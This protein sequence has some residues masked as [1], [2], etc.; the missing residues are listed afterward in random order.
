MSND[1]IGLFNNTDT[2]ELTLAFVFE[3]KKYIAKVS[4]QT[5]Q[6]FSVKDS[7]DSKEIR[8]TM[9]VMKASELVNKYKKSSMLKWKSN[10]IKTF[11]M[12][13]KIQQ[14]E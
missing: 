2:N 13:S 10:D 8:D 6:L 11:D 14:K 4:F 7:T 12:L 5:E 3:K 9:V 1:V